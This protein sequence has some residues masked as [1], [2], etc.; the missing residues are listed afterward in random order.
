MKRGGEKPQQPISKHSCRIKK[1]KRSRRTMQQDTQHRQQHAVDTHKGFGWKRSDKL[2]LVLVAVI[3]EAEWDGGDVDMLW[4]VWRY[5]LPEFPEF[6]GFSCVFVYF[7]EAL[8]GGNFP[9]GRS[10]KSS[11]SYCRQSSQKM[12]RLG[13][14]RKNTSLV[15][16]RVPVRMWISM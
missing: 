12:W 8:Q 5:Q 10:W 16:V 2:N 15:T 6:L 9:C 14:D 3:Y 11:V 4:V 1:K 13:V 7:R